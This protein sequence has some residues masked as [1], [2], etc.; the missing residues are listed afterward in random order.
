MASAYMHK[1]TL[2]QIHTPDGPPGIKARLFVLSEPHTDQAD[3]TRELLFNSTAAFCWSQMFLHFFGLFLVS[4]RQRQKYNASIML[5]KLLQSSLYSTTVTGSYFCCINP[6]LPQ[7]HIKEE[8]C[9]V[10]TVFS[11]CTSQAG[12]NLSAALQQEIIWNNICIFQGPVRS[13]LL[14]NCHY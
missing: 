6:T 10:S 9:T 11:T 12:N 7:T 13:Y 4:D 2:A 5:W 1:H 14:N 3:L 8:T